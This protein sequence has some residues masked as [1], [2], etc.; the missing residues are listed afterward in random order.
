MAQDKKDAPS[1]GGSQTQQGSD[2]VSQHKRL[3]MGQN[4]P[5]V[6]PGPKTPP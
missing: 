2:R 5:V 6:A 4:P 1:K 3:A